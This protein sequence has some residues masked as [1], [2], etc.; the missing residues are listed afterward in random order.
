VRSRAK[1]VNHVMTVVR[2]VKS[3]CTAEP[4]YNS[5][6]DSCKKGEFS[7]RIAKAIPHVIIVVNKVKLPPCI[8]EQRL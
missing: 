1:A 8:A 7:P 3:P 4:S 2:K 5:R 6:D